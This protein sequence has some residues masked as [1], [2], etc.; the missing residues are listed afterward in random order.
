MAAAKKVEWKFPDRKIIF[1]KLETFTIAVLGLLVF[2]FSFLQLDNFFFAVVYT[3]VFFG[4]YAIIAYLIQLIR[5]VE[6]HYQ[7]L[8][9]HLHITRKTRFRTKKEKI[10]LKKIKLHKLD[11]FFLGG[12]LVTERKR[13]ALFFNTKKELEKFERLLKEWLQK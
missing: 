9:P 4:L 11:R 6:E 13:H 10:H 8:P 2:L 5:T 1:M 3:L 7:L 12:Y